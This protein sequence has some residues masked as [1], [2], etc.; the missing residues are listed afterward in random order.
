[1]EMMSRCVVLLGRV[2]LR[3]DR[4]ARSSQ[5]LRVRVVAVA[6]ADPGGVHPALQEG[7]P[8]E[9]LVPLLAVGVVEPLFERRGQVVIHERLS[10][11]VPFG[12]L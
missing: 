6:A 10:G 1:M 9:D 3:A 7:A 5:R 4:I 12:Q 11:G 2:A 8:G